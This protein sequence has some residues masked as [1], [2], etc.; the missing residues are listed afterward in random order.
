MKKMFFWG[1]V[2]LL[3]VITLWGCAKEVEIEDVVRD[4]QWFVSISATKEDDATRALTLSGNTL[5][6]SWTSGDVVSVTKN[7]TSVGTL[8][9]KTSGTQTALEGSLTGPFYASDNLTLSFLAQDYTGQD[10]TI[11][12]IASHCDYAVATVSI[13]STSGGV[14]VTSPAVFKNQ[15]A[16]TSFS[17]TDGT[18]ALFPSS[19]TISSSS[20]KLVQKYQSGSPVYGNITVNPG[21]SYIIALR[22]ESGASDTYTFMAMVGEEL[23]IGEK[24]AN[25]VNGKYYATSVT[26]AKYELETVDLGLS[27]EWATCNLDA[28]SPENA[29]GHYAWGEMTTKSY[30]GEYYYDDPSTFGYYNFNDHPVMGDLSQ[31]EDVVS[32]RFASRWI[33]MPSKTECEEL[34]NNCTWTKTTLNGKPVFKATSKRNNKSIYF[35]TSGRRF[36]DGLY[37]TD[38]EMTVWSK[39]ACSTGSSSDR[40]AWSLTNDAGNLT[41]PIVEG[42]HKPLGFNIRPVKEN[43]VLM[44]SITLNR[45]SITI[46][47][48][49]Y[50]NL[51]ATIAPDNTY[52]KTITWSSSKT[53]VATVDQNGKVTAVAN[54]SAIITVSNRDGSVS[55]TCSVTVVT[56]TTV[57]GA[58]DMGTSVL[59]ATANLGASTYTSMGS[60]YRWG[61]TAT[62][63]NSG[64]GY[65]KYSNDSG[66]LTKYCSNSAY[67]LDGFT[68][69]LT[70]LESSD[71]AAAVK[72]KSK[73]RIPTSEEFKELTDNCT[74][75]WV[76]GDVQLVKFTSNLNGAILYFPVTGTYF[77]SDDDCWFRDFYWSA[78]IH[79]YKSGNTLKT[80]D[81]YADC[82]VINEKN[83]SYYSH[84][85]QLRHNIYYIRPVYAK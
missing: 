65:Y 4:N 37:Y 70:V 17:F 34:L 38:S 74:T 84:S 22:N 57:S 56:S 43:P 36:D 11:E 63:S 79:T 41:T 9:A 50:F 72:L 5:S 27:V 76:D 8:T 49:S 54:G 40:F 16:I 14:L 3:V 31:E 33:R 47:R 20:G 6:A 12:Y 58:V 45:E 29:G 23:Y 26:L 2:T 25:L 28:T 83:S 59:W 66:L 10:G 62:S 81:K 46:P 68:D 21:S 18:R 52:D 82:F 48:G 32:Q 44:A 13:T 77:D 53:S 85:Y 42:R 15:Q 30:Y 71:D 64:W 55:S 67:G 35:P 75:D 51:S 1:S 24:K 7:G 19:I 78:S 80:Q 69:N 39:T 60:V 61:E 73:W